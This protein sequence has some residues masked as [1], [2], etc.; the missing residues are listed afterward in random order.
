[1]AFGPMSVGSENTLTLVTDP[2]L[3]IENISADAKAAGDAL[4]RKFDKSG[5]TVS[6]NISF[7]SIGD[8][9][10]GK[11]IIWEGSSDG[12]EIYYQ[13]TA[14][15]K[16]N[17]VLNLLDDANC[18]LQIA[19]GGVFRSYFTPNDGNF[20]GNVNGRADTAG[21]ADKAGEVGGYKIRSQSSDPGVGSALESGVVLMV[22]E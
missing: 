18:M 16:G 21:M 11:K 19:A 17:L 7:P 3:S 4:R 10:T 12:A 2:T 15:D 14:K 5:G 1:M 9:E 6:G 8:N 20:H 22:Y 13:T